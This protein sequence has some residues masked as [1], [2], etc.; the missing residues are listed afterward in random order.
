MYSFI[1][2]VLS[3]C[4]VLGTGYKYQKKVPS[5]PKNMIFTISDSTV[6]IF[7]DRG[8]KKTQQIFW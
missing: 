3:D 7:D 8:L 4:S 1:K 6:F 2:Y 5:S